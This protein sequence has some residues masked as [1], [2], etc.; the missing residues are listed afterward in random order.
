[1]DI[2]ERVILVCLFFFITDG[3][4]LLIFIL[5][6]SSALMDNTSKIIIAVFC[7]FLGIVVCICFA[8]YRVYFQQGECRMLCDYETRV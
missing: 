7:G 3:N 1:M 8:V 5:A 6:R 2:K 4:I